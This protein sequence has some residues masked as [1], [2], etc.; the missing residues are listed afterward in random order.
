MSRKLL[1]SKAKSLE[2]ILRIG[3][4]GLSESMVKEIN[5]ILRQSRGQGQKRA[6]RRNCR[7]NRL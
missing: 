1:K 4:N 5:S 3:K 6:C 2:P 7:K